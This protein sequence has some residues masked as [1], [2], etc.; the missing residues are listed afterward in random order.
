MAT[1][2]R[3]WTKTRKVSCCMDETGSQWQYYRILEAENDEVFIENFST[4]TFIYFL[5]IRLNK[6]D[7][8]SFPDLVRSQRK[9]VTVGIP[10]RPISPNVV[11]E[12]V[13]SPVPTRHQAGDLIEV[14][15]KRKRCKELT[16]ENQSKGPQKWFGIL[17]H[18]KTKSIPNHWEFGHPV[19]VAAYKS[20]AT[21]SCLGEPGSQAR[22]GSAAWWQAFPPD[23]GDSSEAVMEGNSPEKKIP[24]WRSQMD[25]SA[26]SGTVPPNHHP[27]QYCRVFHF[28]PPSI[29][30]YLPQFL[31]TP[32]WL[33]G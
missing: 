14:P 27:F 1:E 29:L 9:D 33:R 28:E 3:N 4:W 15:L 19:F 8:S 12:A 20:A 25:V 2:S 6:D 5:S 10:G 26:N 31:E 24:K 7:S 21:S 13:R 16:A 17:K 30:G 11:S 22:R 32:K 18:T 23:S